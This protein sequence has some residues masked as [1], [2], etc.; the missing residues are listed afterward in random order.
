ML[1]DIFI[2]L[3]KRNP[4]YSLDQLLYGTYHSMKTDLLFERVK[5]DILGYVSIHEMGYYLRAVD[6]K[7]RNYVQENIF[8]SDDPNL[9]NYQL[10][11]AI[12]AIRRSF[13]LNETFHLN[14]NPNM[15]FAIAA[16][17]DIWNCVDHSIHEKIA[18]E[19]FMEDLEMKTFFSD[20]DRVVIQQAIQDHRT[21]MK[22]EPRSVYGK[23]ISSANYSTTIQ[24]AFIR[25]FLSEQ[26]E[27]LGMTLEQYLDYTIKQF[28]DRY[29]EKIPENMFFTDGIYKIFLKDMKGLL[30]R[31][32][33]FKD[34]YCR[35]NGITDQ[36]KK[37]E[38]YLGDATSLKIYQKTLN[39]K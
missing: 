36:S 27:S 25:N 26:E 28:K 2:D 39:K 33:E 9:L 32:K 30:Q 5:E 17:H 11:P 16:Y 13:A 14:L 31:E 20:E 19:K 18:A 10:L 4:E 23:L 34:L 12:E 24:D 29:Y 1:K 38:E 7:L 21:T 8:S 37:V 15:I 6:P 35:I 22:N 3:K